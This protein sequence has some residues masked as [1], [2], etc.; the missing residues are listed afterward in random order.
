MSDAEK[1]KIPGRWQPGQ[2][3]NIA[4]RP[5]GSRNKFS[6]TFMR[7]LAATWA[8]RGGDI[9]D[10]VAADEPGKFLAVSCLTYSARRISESYSAV[11]GQPRTRELGAGRRVISGNQDR[12]ARRQ[13]TA[14]RRGYGF[15]AG[16]DQSA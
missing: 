6:E 8:E 13:P 5:L 1:P 3:G 7:D 12:P 15:R 10:R 16:S 14:A 9:L 4:G 2:S 11:A